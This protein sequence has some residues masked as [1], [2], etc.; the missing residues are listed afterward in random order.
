MNGK[1]V[2]V[3]I[4]VVTLRKLFGLDLDANGMRQYLQSVAIKKD[5]IRTSEDWL[6]STYGPQLTDLLFR[7]YIRRRWGRDFTNWTGQ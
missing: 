5:E 7:H 1:L 6:L 2:P 3:P 4:N